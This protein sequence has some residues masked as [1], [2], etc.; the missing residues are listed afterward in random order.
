MHTNHVAKNLEAASGPEPARDTETWSAMIP[1]GRTP[2]ATAVFEGSRGV[3]DAQGGA[4]LCS[5]ASAASSSS[6]FSYATTSRMSF[7]SLPGHGF[8]KG[9]KR[10]FAMSNLYAMQSTNGDWF[11]FEDSA[12]LRMPVFS[13]RHAAMRARV[14]NGGMLLF[15]PVVFDESALGALAPTGGASGVHFWLAD[16]SSTELGHGQLIDYAQ[17]ALLMHEPTGRPQE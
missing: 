9:M 6:R 1:A 16:G 2:P 13:S 14:R 12:H 4:R 15:K 10:G 11:A 8:G 7:I 3:P 5:P 17:F